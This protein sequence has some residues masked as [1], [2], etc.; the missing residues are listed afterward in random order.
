M[1]KLSFVNEYEHCSKII[2]NNYTL[3]IIFF[4]SFEVFGL[5]IEYL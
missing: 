4:N 3:L 5:D 1:C 2:Q